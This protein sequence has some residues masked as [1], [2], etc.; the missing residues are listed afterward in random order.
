MVTFGFCSF[1]YLLIHIPASF[2]A[3]LTS[4]RQRGDKLHLVVAP[5]VGGNC[6]TT[7]NANI[8]LVAVQPWAVQNSHLSPDSVILAG[9]TRRCDAAMCAALI[10]PQYWR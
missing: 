7:M 9:Y 4:A 6:I 2:C 10:M 8:G 5:K 3:G 1:E